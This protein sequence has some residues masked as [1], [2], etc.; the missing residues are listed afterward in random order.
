MVIAGCSEA[1]DVKHHYAINWA[2]HAWAALADYWTDRF[3]RY[4][5][6]AM[7]TTLLTVG[8]FDPNRYEQSVEVRVLGAAGAFFL[9]MRLQRVLLSFS[10]FG[11]YVFMVFIMMED[12]LS[13]LVILALFPVAFAASLSKLLE[14]PSSTR[15][16]SLEW[17]P[18]NIAPLFDDCSGHFESFP[19]ALIFLS[20]Q[21][22]TGENFFACARNSKYPI[23]VWLIAFFYITFAGLLLLN[24]LIA[25]MAQ[26]FDQ[27]SNDKVMNYIFLRSQM[28]HST[29]KQPM[30]PPP[31]YLLT[32]PYE[33]ILRPSI[34]FLGEVARSGQV[35]KA[36]PLECI[37]PFIGWELIT[38]ADGAEHSSSIPGRQFESARLST[39]LRERVF[40]LRTQEQV[41]ELCASGGCSPLLVTFTETEFNAFKVTGLRRDSF[42]KVESD[43][44][45]KF[46]LYF[47][48]DFCCGI[49]PPPTWWKEIGMMPPAGARP[50][51]EITVHAFLRVLRV[52][53]NSALQRKSVQRAVCFSLAELNQLG[54]HADVVKWDSFARV[55]KLH[56]ELDV[57]FQIDAREAELEYASRDKQL[58][59]AKRLQKYIEEFDDDD[60]H[61]D[62][63]RETVK[64]DTSQA[65]QTVAT[66]QEQVANVQDSLKEMKPDETNAEKLDRYK[67]QLD[68]APE[69][70]EQ[71]LALKQWMQSSLSSMEAS[72]LR[73]MEHEKHRNNGVMPPERS[74]TAMHSRGF[75][76]ASP[77]V[78]A[79]LHEGT[80]HGREHTPL[81]AARVGRGGSLSMYPSRQ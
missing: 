64:R 39:A 21:A 55:A 12:V 63:W 67:R 25:M 58:R 48:P 33:C 57:F 6:P 41:F 27:G 62:R 78:P 37:P 61:Q 44:H 42:I 59:N 30:A 1:V 16:D 45:V 71:I 14:P 15:D 9:W 10:R 5:F 79:P 56:G 17:L 47:R 68:R 34:A 74:S 38:W 8:L 53:V 35:A 51:S 43:G 4:D 46:P 72:I 31:F 77:M 76:L 32:L 22:I 70:S 24:M 23:V 11:P 52:K 3:N 26:S 49:R 36:P 66:V 19:N 80:A 28:V 50:D 65:L 73:K 13:Y 60:A 18:T 69:V 81:N 75:P 54:V 40:E 20:E 7:V 2:K 29:A